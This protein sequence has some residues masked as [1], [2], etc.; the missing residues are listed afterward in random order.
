MAIQDGTPFT[1]KSNSLGAYA[2]ADLLIEHLHQSPSPVKPVES[3]WV[4]GILQANHVSD[5]LLPPCTHK[6]K[7]KILLDLPDFIGVN[8][9]YS[10]F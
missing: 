2:I 6:W 4:R 9:S 3:M 5:F 10:D 7:K 1:P 8:G